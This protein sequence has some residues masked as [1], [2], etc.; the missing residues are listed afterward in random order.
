MAVVFVT[1]M[2]GA[3]KSTALAELGRRGYRAVDTDHGDWIEPGAEPRWREDR[4][5]ALLTEH[6]RSGEPLFL[7]GTV[8]NQGTFYPRFDEVVLLSAPVAVLLARVAGREHNP[9]GRSDEERRQIAADTAEF[10]PVLRASATVEINTQDPPDMVVE[11]L[12]ALAGPV[13]PPR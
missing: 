5:D 7:A 10:E 8:R 2:S 9:F 6:E 11:R 3:G 12:A 1:G 4:I 13:P